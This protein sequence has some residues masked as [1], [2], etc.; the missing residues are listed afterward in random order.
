MAAPPVRGASA[1]TLSLW[2]KQSSGAIWEVWLLP[3][4]ACTDSSH[5]DT[6]HARPGGGHS[7]MAGW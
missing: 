4:R 2:D 3:G 7:T 6:H 5:G 1:N